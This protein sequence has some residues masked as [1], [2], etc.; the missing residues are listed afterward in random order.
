MDQLLLR[1]DQTR[2]GFEKVEPPDGLVIV[3]FGSSSGAY[4]KRS[5]PIVSISLLFGS[6]SGV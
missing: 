1:L 6:T 3:L 4:K 2:E 5:P